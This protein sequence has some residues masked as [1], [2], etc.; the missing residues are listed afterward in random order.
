MLES[1]GISTYLHTISIHYICQVVITTI[2]GVL[3]KARLSLQRALLLRLMII[4]ILSAQESINRSDTSRTL[5]HT[6]CIINESIC[7]IALS[8]CINPGFVALTLI[9]NCCEFTSYIVPKVLVLALLYICETPPAIV[10]TICTT[11]S[12][13]ITP[14]LLLTILRVLVV[15]CISVRYVTLIP[16]ILTFPCISSNG[17]L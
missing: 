2:T 4:V 9:P 10:L 13:T 3:P 1:K 16:R 8:R 17:G 6:D 11:E 12:R 5:K 14:S 7:L 15:T